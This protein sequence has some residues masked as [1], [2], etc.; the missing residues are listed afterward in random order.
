MYY[1]LPH[2][3][4]Q[5]A[6]HKVYTLATSVGQATMQSSRD[7]GHAAPPAD[8]PDPLEAFPPAPPRAYDIAAVVLIVLSSPMFR[9]LL[10]GFLP[11]PF[12]LL[13]TLSTIGPSVDSADSSEKLSV[14]QKTRSL[15]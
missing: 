1:L 7:P 13:G 4:P 12:R 6:T 2:T 5:L 10:V 8:P 9:G 3:L 15:H 14:G 11:F